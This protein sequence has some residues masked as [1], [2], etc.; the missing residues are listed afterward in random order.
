VS[1][2]AASSDDDKPGLFEY[3]DPLLSPHAYPNG[4]SPDSKPNSNSDVFPVKPQP[5]EEIYEKSATMAAST[6]GST[7]QR[8]EANLPNENDLFDPRISPYAYPQVQTE[9]ANHNK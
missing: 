7:N 1:L 5:L 3:F 2:Q 9:K 6:E 4:I 8:K